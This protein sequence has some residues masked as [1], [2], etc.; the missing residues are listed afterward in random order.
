MKKAWLAYAVFLVLVVVLGEVANIAKGKEVT[1]LKLLNWVGASLICVAVFGYALQR[2]ILSAPIW[3]LILW[4]VVSLSLALVAYMVFK[5][6]IVSLVG[7]L[8]VLPFIFPAYLAVYW[9]AY[10][11]ANIWQQMP[12]N[13]LQARRP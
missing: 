1:L 13:S 10:S 7:I 6:G 3:K 4:I 2:K 11:S 12:N 5:S 9:Y 8:I